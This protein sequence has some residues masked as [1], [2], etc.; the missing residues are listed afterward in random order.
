VAA[1]GEKV[2]ADVAAEPH[3]RQLAFR[4]AAS[5]LAIGY[6]RM[7][8]LA[9][10][11]A[12]AARTP[13]DCEVCLAARG[14]VAEMAGDHAAAE[15]WFA[16]LK[17]A[18]PNLPMADTQWG[19]ALLGRGDMDG[20][21]VELKRAHALGPHFADPLELWAEALMAKRDY[22]G[23]IAKFA[24]A[25]PEA[26]RWGRNHMLWGEALMLSGRYAEARAQYEAANGMDL[27]KPDRAALSVLLVRTASGRLHV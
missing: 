6:A 16:E 22:A 2:F 26:P 5:G 24:E 8:R 23:A 25:D 15:R 13:L 7:G 18:D 14:S 17:R 11:Q 1:V 12:L 4:E 10:A 27:S 3:T 9:E 19:A 20:A 21:I